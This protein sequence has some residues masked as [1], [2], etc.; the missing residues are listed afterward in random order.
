MTRELLS[1]Y[2]MVW[3]RR[4]YKEIGLKKLLL[5]RHWLTSENNVP[6]KIRN[7]N[8]RLSRKLFLEYTSFYRE[9]E[10]CYLKEARAMLENKHW[11]NKNKCVKLI[12]D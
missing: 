9:H 4:A 10:R 11:E 3:L 6:P 8:Y 12:G 7:R 2:D 1:Y 5:A